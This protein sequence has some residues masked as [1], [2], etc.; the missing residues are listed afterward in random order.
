LAAGKPRL[1]V[2]RETM[3]FLAE[4]DGIEG[5]TVESRASDPPGILAITCVVESEVLE[6]LIAAAR[7]ASVALYDPTRNDLLV[8]SAGVVTETENRDSSFASQ[9]QAAIDAESST[10]ASAIRRS[11][12]RALGGVPIEQSLGLRGPVATPFAVPPR[13]L[14]AIPEEVPP[15]RQVR[16]TRTRLLRDLYA[17]SDNVRRAAAIDLAGWAAD[18]AI[19]DGLRAALADETDLY[20]RS[21]L[22]LSLAVRGASSAADH[23]TISDSIVDAALETPHPWGAI[24]SVL[25]ILAAAIAAARE[26]DALA[27]QRLHHTTH[28]AMPLGQQQALS[29]LDAMLS[30]F[31][32]SNR[33]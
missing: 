14:F 22:S 13:L 25:G 15:S 12:Q 10:D 5:V 6:S 20:V 21:V 2:T 16:S 26:N 18:V 23:L 3:R 9:I 19:D 28:R 8:S 30:E 1:A 17:A 27:F 24:A 32:V 33:S 4:I 11:A 31:G 29:E 7:A